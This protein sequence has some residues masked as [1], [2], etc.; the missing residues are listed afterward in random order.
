[1]KSPLGD[2]HPVALVKYRALGRVGDDCIIED[3]NGERLVLGEDGHAGDP[4]TLPLLPLLP[5]EARHDQL[6]L[7][8]FHHQLDSQKLH[9]KPLSI[10]TA[11]EVIRLTY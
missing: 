4:P 2:R 1:L 6:M 9:A 10:V 11:S 3:P 7:V 5:K 8:R